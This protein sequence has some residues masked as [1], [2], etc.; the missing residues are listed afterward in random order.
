MDELAAALDALASDDLPTVSGPQLL[1]RLRSLLTAQNRLAAEVARTVRQCELT[2]AAEHDGLKTMASW[3]RGHG[4]LSAA[5]AG[6][7]VAVGRALEQLPAVAAACAAGAVTAGQAAVIA[8]V[9][10]P[11][12]LARA[13]EHDVDLLGVDAAPAVLAASAPSADVE[14]AV[15]HCLQRLDPDGPEPEPTEGRAL[16]LARHADGS[17]SGRFHLD[18]AGGEKLQAAVESVVQADRPAGDERSRAQRQGSAAGR[19]AGA[20]LRH[21]AGCRQPAHAARTQ[22]ADRRGD[23]P[24]GPRR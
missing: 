7:V 16:V 11:G 2:S 20:G 14:A 12:N 18:A 10:E 21:R 22:A 5:E 3:L 6:R 1:E 23:R 19:R 13:A 24:G 15:H 17:L 9:A 8:P 4:H